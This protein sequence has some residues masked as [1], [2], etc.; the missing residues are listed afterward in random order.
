M[1]VG[2]GVPVVIEKVAI[3]IVTIVTPLQK[4]NHIHL[5]IRGIIFRR[6]KKNQ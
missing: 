4:N 3:S 2:S 5:K 1:L 6:I